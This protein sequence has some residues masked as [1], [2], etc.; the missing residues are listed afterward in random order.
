M[1]E[2]IS[3]PIAGQFM[4]SRCENF[5]NLT[6]C[7]S[8][9]MAVL[10]LK[11]VQRWM[12]MME[13]VSAIGI[14]D[15]KIESLEVQWMKMRTRFQSPKATTKG[16]SLVSLHGGWTK[17][18]L[19][20]SYLNIF[21]KQSFSASQEDHVPVFRCT[22]SLPETSTPI[23]HCRRMRI[24]NGEEECGDEELSLSLSSAHP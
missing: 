14:T 19:N 7:R 17:I 9:F 20:H 6:V 22:N 15:T 5:C 16:Y 18:I 2:K 23:K 8:C 3:L 21:I 24:S 11:D 10:K 12:M 4:L 1:A 13:H